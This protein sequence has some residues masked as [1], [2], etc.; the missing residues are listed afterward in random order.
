[1]NGK[2]QKARQTKSFGY[3]IFIIM[4][5]LICTQLQAAQTA[6]PAARPNIILILADDQGWNGLSARMDPNL[7]GSGSTYYN[8]PNIAKL[9]AQGF[10]FSQAY[11]AAATCGPSRRSI[12]YGRSPSSLE[13]FASPKWGKTNLTGKPSES[14]IVTLKKV[15]P[16]Y[17]AAH[18]GKW[19]MPT[20]P[21]DL[22]YDFNDG[23][24]SNGTGQSDDV[25]DPKRI[26]ELSR[27][28]V[29]FIEKQVKASKP[30]YLQISHYANHT[31]YQAL[32]KTINKYETEHADKATKYQN[33]PLWAAMNEN[34]DTGV[35]MV[36]DKIKELGIEDNTYVIYT[37]DNGFEGRGSAQLPVEERKF[38]KAYPLM[39]HKYVIN[40]GGI[41]VPFIVRGPGI[42][43]GGYSKERVVGYDIFPTILD[44]LGFVD[45]VP[46]VV[47]G[48]SLLPLLQSG[49]KKKVVRK[50]PFMVF[51]Y[52]RD[53]RDVCIIQDDYKLLKEIDSGKMHLW[54]IDEDLSEQNNLLKEQPERAEKMYATMTEYFKRFDWDE[55]QSIERD[56]SKDNKQ[57][58]TSRH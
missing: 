7:P 2:K 32:Q 31:K 38:H 17:V 34:L 49:G 25:N 23:K 13:I 45:D 3:G 46:E 37:A 44:L 42:P 22:G 50:N 15:C 58:G 18:F 12:Q 27:K 29:D 33:S 48:G 43:A 41:R 4:L 10:R 5:S 1:M 9:A 54:K 57:K 52:T 56:F 28:S 11:S 30:F 55:S 39:A 24:N 8:T 51:R 36:L 19:H 40:E 21:K 26:F 53:A 14:L 6:K 35:G 16:E 47:E 20:S